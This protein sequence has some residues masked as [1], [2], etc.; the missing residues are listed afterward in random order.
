MNSPAPLAWL[1]ERCDLDCVLV[2]GVF[3]SGRPRRRHDL[4]L[5]PA[6]VRPAGPGAPD[7]RHLQQLRHPASRG[8]A[9]VHPAPPRRD[10]CGSSSSSRRAARRRSRQTPLPLHP[11]P[12]TRY[13]LSWKHSGMIARIFS[14]SLGRLKILHDHGI[15]RVRSM[16]IT[17]V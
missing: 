12:R 2:A 1:V 6:L 14:F 3:N 13:G 5:R 17:A 11:H 15:S 9:P 16:V 4:R 8:G 7:A 10:G